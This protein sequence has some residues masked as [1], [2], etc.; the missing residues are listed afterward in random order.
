MPIPLYDP[1]QPL[2]R[3]LV[4][5]ATRAEEIAASLELPAQSFQALRRRVRQALETD[6]VA[7]DLDNAVRALLNP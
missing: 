6:G 7:A 5:L 3:D 1:Q 4:H 2:H